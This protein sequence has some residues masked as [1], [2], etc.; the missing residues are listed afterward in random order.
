MEWCYPLVGLNFN[1]TN[2]QP[3]GNP[4]PLLT[5]LQPYNYTTITRRRPW[6]H[7]WPHYLYLY[8]H[9]YNTT[10]SH[11]VCKLIEESIRTRTVCECTKIPVVHSPNLLHN[12]RVLCNPQINAQRYPL[13][14]PL[15]YC[16]TQGDCNFRR[17]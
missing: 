5:P 12:A 2:H 9:P 16:A 13:R 11:C 3:T 10:H 15:A 4:T 14:N 6:P 7:Y 1:P 17:K 8:K